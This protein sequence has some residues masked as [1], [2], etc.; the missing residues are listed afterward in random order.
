MVL[1]QNIYKRR[2][3]ARIE[4]RQ[5]ATN[6]ANPR[7][8]AQIPR[9]ARTAQRAERSKARR[10]VMSAKGACKDPRFNYLYQCLSPLLTICEDRSS[11]STSGPVKSSST[12]GTWIW[13]Y[14]NSVSDPMI[15]A[16]ELVGQGTYARVQGGV[17]ESNATLVVPERKENW[18][19]FPSQP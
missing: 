2:G 8:S 14:V 6:R 15:L 18:L 5:I 17:V 19:G 1:T 11:E 13:W 16:D 10:N 9:I 12:A 4:W 7:Q 3:T